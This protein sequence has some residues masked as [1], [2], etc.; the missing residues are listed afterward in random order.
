MKILI[1]ADPIVY[2]V[3][4]AGEERW[5]E[6]TWWPN[7]RECRAWFYN[8][9]RLDRF[10]E[11]MHIIP[12]E[13][14]ISL[15]RE[16]EPL[17]YILATVK[18][19]LHNIFAAVDGFLAETKHEADEFQLYLTDGESNYRNKIAT[20]APYKGNRD[21]LHKPIYYQ[22]IRDYMVEHWDARIVR[23]A[24]ADDA[25][26]IAQYQSDSYYD[27]VICTIDKDLR[28]IPGFHYNY[29]SKED[30]FVDEKEASIAFYTQLL[31]GDTTDNIKGC[32]KVGAK[33][34]KQLIDGVLEAK[35]WGNE[36]ELQLYGVCLQ[37]YHDS[38][39]KYGKATKYEHLG[40]KAALLENARLL[41]MQRY[42]G[43]LW[44]PPGEP[45]ETI[46]AFED[47]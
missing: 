33:K 19:K 32:Y 44:T 45:D 6:L 22:E 25:V 8:K 46:S 5:Y 9:Y 26:A 2:Q 12:E 11:L 15:E 41:W 3:G 4:F 13:V 47:N 18:R 10:M 31:T 29:M 23:G 39:E 34:A 14:E 20:I 42:P 16:S 27:T 21:P 43:Q 28:M 40:A 1:D 38:I 17:S 7:G 24:E 30:F 36:L 35:L 37:A